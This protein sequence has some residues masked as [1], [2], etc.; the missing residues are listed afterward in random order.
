LGLIAVLVT[1]RLAREERKRDN[2]LKRIESTLEFSRRF[3]ELIRDR[4]HLNRKYSD[5]HEEKKDAQPTSAEKD[6][7]L[8]WWWAFFDLMLYQF[9][10]FQRGLI[11]EERFIEWMRWRWYD[12]NPK[13]DE[14]VWKTCGVTYKD[15][16]DL[17]STRKAHRKNRLIQ[18]LNDVHEADTP[19]EVARIVRAQ[20][21]R[22]GQKTKL[23]I[24]S[25]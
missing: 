5:A 19:G 15:G 6:E 8:V 22:P 2:R 12:F 21:P 1:K 16:W 9:D 20:G 14:E 24:E 4:R 23:D 17:W 10:F 7:G 25:E 18:F 13:P 3:Q 11:R